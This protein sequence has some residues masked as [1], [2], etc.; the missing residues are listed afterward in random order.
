MTPSGVLLLLL[1]FLTPLS[2][3]PEMKLSIKPS[4]SSN[5]S[6]LR[7]KPRP[8]PDGCLWQEAYDWAHVSGGEPMGESMF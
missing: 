4:T 8:Q 5:W 1:L 2:A 7:E 6:V 3:L